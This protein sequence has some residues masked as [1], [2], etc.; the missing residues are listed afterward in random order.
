VELDARW[1]G[2]DL[3]DFFGKKT[4]NLPT[5]PITYYRLTHLPTYLLTDLPTYQLLTYRLNRL[6]D[7]PTY[8]LTEGPAG[9]P[10]TGLSEY[11]HPLPS[12]LLY[13]L[14]YLPSYPVTHLPTYP[15]T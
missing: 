1:G 8:I 4:A 5:Y 11:Q 7:L 6:T 9:R 12:Y 14:T 10:G 3:M 13:P 2:Y 15:L